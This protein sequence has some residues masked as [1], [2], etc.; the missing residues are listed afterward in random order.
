MPHQSVFIIKFLFLHNAAVPILNSFVKGN[1]F[2][3]A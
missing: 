1:R 3:F 2:L